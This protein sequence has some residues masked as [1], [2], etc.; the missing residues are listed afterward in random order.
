MIPYRIET[1]YQHTPW[2]NQAIFGATIATSLAIEAGLVPADAV[3][4]YFVLGAGHPVAFVGC[5]FAHAGLMHLAGNMVFL[6]VFGNAVCAT[7]GNLLYPF[8][9]LLLGVAAGTIH[10]TID[11]NPA[12]GASGAITGLVGVAVALYPLN[13]VS[14]AY[15]LG[16]VP[17]TFKWPL[18]G[19]A[20]YWSAWDAVGAWL[21]LDRVAYWAHL[22]G[23]VCGV[24]GGLTL[25]ALG[26]VTLTEFDHSSL[27]DLL[28]RREPPHKTPAVDLD[29]VAVLA[30]AHQAFG[31]SDLVAIRTTEVPS[32]PEPAVPP[33]PVAR[34][35]LRGGKPAPVSASGHPSAL[36]PLEAGPE[37]G[38]FYFDGSLR[39]GPVSR[40]ALIER[41]RNA[42][43]TSRWWYWV[44][45][46]PEWRRVDEGLR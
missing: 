11:G 20:L 24:G 32:S 26:R 40:A 25:L 6:W 38:Y 8:L 5:L 42:T 44:E 30:R 33:P 21:Q 14:L 15:F 22:G 17:R 28:L 12:I 46:M 13:R 35:R 27:F 34:I 9:Y 19:V 7:V 36:E 39:S 1:L 41:V 3:G 23:M 29:S 16:V 2:A 18:W 43:D 45:G 31:T 37:E 10:L 4:E